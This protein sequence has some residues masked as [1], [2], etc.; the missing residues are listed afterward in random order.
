MVQA[1]DEAAEDGEDEIANGLNDRINDVID[2]YKSKTGVLIDEQGEEYRDPDDPHAFD[3]SDREKLELDGV[4][5]D[6]FTKDEIAELAKRARAR[7]AAKAKDDLDDAVRRHVAD[8]TRLDVSKLNR[9]ELEKLVDANN[10]AFER[11]VLKQYDNLDDPEVRAFLGPDVQ[12]LFADVADIRIPPELADKVSPLGE[13]GDNGDDT[14]ADA[15]DAADDATVPDTSAD[16]DD[17]GGLGGADD[18]G[19]PAAGPVADSDT[20]Q[21]DGGRSVVP[22]ATA[23][24]E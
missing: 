16:V 23:D 22:V 2:S 14:P 13:D 3:Q 20:P 9:D 24:L 21:S 5:I 6:G 15:A 11:A 18:D 7:D 10:D 17:G 12:R 1:R 8:V 4:K 19:P